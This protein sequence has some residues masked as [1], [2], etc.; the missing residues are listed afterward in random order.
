[1]PDGTCRQLNE[2]D[3]LTGSNGDIVGGG[4]DFNTQ[5]FATKF[6]VIQTKHCLFSLFD[7]AEV[8]REKKRKIKTIVER[9]ARLITT[10]P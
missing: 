10:K 5:A 3:R 6:F 7:A 4:T 8:L 2:H 1:M 9:R